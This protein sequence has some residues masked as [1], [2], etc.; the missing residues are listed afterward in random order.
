[1]G[2]EKDSSGVDGVVEKKE[3]MQ[4][5]ADDGSDPGCSVPSE[6]V[7]DS[8][9]GEVREEDVA[10][11]GDV[12]KLASVAIMGEGLCFCGVGFDLKELALYKMIP[13]REREAV[14]A[15]DDLG[16]SIHQRVG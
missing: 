2:S 13:K 5:P 9:K 7:V 8:G 10:L 16:I 4:A 11:N 3:T 15:R 12:N 14:M 6:V 1:M